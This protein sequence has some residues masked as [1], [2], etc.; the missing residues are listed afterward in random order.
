MTT[1]KQPDENKPS[2]QTGEEFGKIKQPQ[3]TDRTMH[4]EDTARG[5]EVSG[6][7]HAG[8]RGG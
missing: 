7:Q 1:P 5:A 4:D 8:H 6:R 3:Q 2:H